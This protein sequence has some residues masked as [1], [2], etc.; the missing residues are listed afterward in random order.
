M[1][2]VR[3]AVFCLIFLSASS[4]INSQEIKP[5]TGIE[6]SPLLSG[7]SNYGWEL[8]AAYPLVGLQTEIFRLSAFAGGGLSVRDL[9]SDERTIWSWDSE[10]G[11]SWGEDF[12]WTYS[13]G[14]NLEVLLDE[15]Q[16]GIG[17]GMAG[18]NLVDKDKFLYPFIRV[19]AGILIG[20]METKLYYDYNFD[21]NGYKVGLLVGIYTAKS[22]YTPPP[23]SPS[24][25]PPPP[26]PPSPPKP[27][28]VDPSP[29]LEEPPVE[30]NNG[31][32]IYYQYDGTGYV[33][34]SEN[35]FYLCYN[36]RPVGY[37]ERGVI[38]SF[39]GAVLGFYEKSFIYDRNGNPVGAADPKSL[40][41]DAAGKKSVTK[42]NKQDVPVRQTQASVNK[43]RLKNGYFGGSLRDVF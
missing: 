22:S 21:N 31:G 38:Y 1:K 8:F 25:S 7:S 41:T 6:F 28:P 17:G 36:G 39:G 12:T 29:R 40:G 37:I 2:K 9:F 27:R 32:T 43:P 14:G 16:V 5:V 35:V 26:P 18:P 42:A 3:I 30:K 4:I 15:W 34:V 10:E 11:F 19:S 20:D 13:F 24:P 33:F 23:W